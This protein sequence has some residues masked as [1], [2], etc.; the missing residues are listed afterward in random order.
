MK[1]IISS[2]L[3][4]AGENIRENLL[5]TYP[6]EKLD[7]N[8]FYDKDK[9]SLL[10]RIKNETIYTDFPENIIQEE[11]KEYNLT[12]ID[13]IYFATRHKSVAKIPTLTCHTPGNFGKADYGGKD[14]KVSPSNPIFQKLVLNQ[15]NNLSKK[16]D[17]PFEVSL[18][19]THHGPLTGLPTTFIEIG[20]DEPY[21]SIKEAGGVIA[22]AIYNSLSYKDNEYS[23]K[24]AAGIGGGH[25]CPKF[26]E[27]ILHTDIALGHVIA[28]YNTPV[29][30]SILSELIRKSG[31][32]DFV[33]LDWKGIKERSDLKDKLLNRGISFVKTG[34]IVKE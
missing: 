32:L 28:K 5:E 1:L 25:Y 9:D 23:F 15:I 13:S 22:S 26:T 27:I 17:I 8:Y 18:E 30:D 24:I 2:E 19:A 16:L 6:F 10:V 11:I 20:S 34:D 31:R 12:E 3:D 14:G 7:N 4:K 33:I 21:W 29:T